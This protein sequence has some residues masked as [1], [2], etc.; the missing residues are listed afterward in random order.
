MRLVANARMYSVN[1]AAAAAWKELFG[2]LAREAGVELDV[3]AHAFPLPLS[4][5]WSRDDLACA[6]MCGYP[7][8]LAGKR[9]QPVAA[10]VP[11]GAPVRGRAVY[12]TRLLVRADSKFETIEDTFGGR[13]GY[14][15]TD[16]HS[17]YNALRHHLLPYFQRRGAR[18]Y[19]ESVGPLTTPRRV[20]DALQAGDID[21][22]PL[23]SY[24]LELMLHHEVDLLSKIRILATT[25]PAPIPFLVAAPGCPADAVARLQAALA[26]FGEASDC[27]D[28]REQLGL[29][30]FA[31][32]NIDDYQLMLRWDAEARAVGYAEPG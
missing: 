8:M 31:P 5:L 27:A 7:F 2:W 32:V 24:A 19:R 28:L 11:A 6:F 12:A 10:P 20:L 4:D 21:I 13:I 15:V 3:I 30:R 26:S 23:D 9:P 14:T 22:G 16:S 18:L 29:E 17:G 25:E 1:S